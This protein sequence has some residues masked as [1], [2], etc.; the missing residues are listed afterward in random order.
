MRH[1]FEHVRHHAALGQQRV[2]HRSQLGRDLLTLKQRDAR[3]SLIRGHQ[4][5]HRKE[6]WIK[7][8]L[9]TVLTILPN[10]PGF[11]T[12]LEEGL[13]KLAWSQMLKK[14][15]VNRIFWR[16]V[17]RKFF[18]SEKSQFCRNGPR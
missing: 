16:S 9:P 18:I 7:R 10:A 8:G 17:N 2:I 6:S 15:T 11:S 13:A 1:G 4:N 12:S 3:R 14:S 5:A